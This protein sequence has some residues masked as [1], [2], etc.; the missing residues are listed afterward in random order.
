M[1]VGIIDV[2][3]HNYPNLALM[4]IA[5]H[6]KEQ[7][8]EVEWWCGLKHYDRVYEAKV[9]G[10]EYTKDNEF[11]IQ[12]DEIIKGGTGYNLDGKL[13]DEI[14]HICP[15]Y[16]IY[17]I[18]DT[19]YGFLTRGCPRNCGFCIVGQKEGLKSH[20]VADLSEFWSGQKNIE[21]LDPNLLASE[22]REPLL[23][24]LVESGADVNFNQGLDIRFVDD[25][26]INLI[27][28][29]KT[30]MVHFA[31]DTYDFGIYETLKKYRHRFEKRGRELRVYV[32][33]NYNTTHEEDVD[34]VEKLKSMDY[35]PFVMIY[36]KPMAPKE[37]RA[38][39]RYANNKY[40][41]ETCKSF[42]EYCGNR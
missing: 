30:K 6:E 19:A 21:I 36:N 18:K 27:N 11:V 34:R 4:K 28:N 7:G 37:T 32:L 35:D 40:I 39:Q 42:A 8:N 10:P 33:T 22:E 9:F 12:A 24:Q 3:G 23:E 29:I 25:R 2:D 14:E 1:D 20:K 15:D 26:I 41:F 17:N 16:S 13:P 5:A 31:W 38:L